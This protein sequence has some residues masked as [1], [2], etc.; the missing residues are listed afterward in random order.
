LC[1]FSFSI[2]KGPKTERSAYDKSAGQRVKEWVFEEM[3]L[4]AK[5]GRG[6]T[7]LR[8]AQTAIRIFSNGKAILASLA[9]LRAKVMG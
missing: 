1:S 9:A 8:Y 2:S 3:P 7:N 4:S 6:G 5:S